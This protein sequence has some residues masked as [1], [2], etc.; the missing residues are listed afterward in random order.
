[1]QL[2]DEIISK[3]KNSH[4][5]KGFTILDDHYIVICDN[6][7]EYVEKA[8]R[9]HEQ[10]VNYCGPIECKTIDGITYALEY[11]APGVEMN[12]YYKFCDEI[13]KSAE[14]YISFFSDY[15]NTLK[16]L[17]DAPKKQYFKF[18]DDIEKMKKEGIRPDYCHYGNLF[19]DK[20]VG[21]SF[22]DVYPIRD[23]T[24]Y[25]LPVRHIFYIILNPKFNMRT[26][27]GRISVLPQ[28]LEK[29][30]NMYIYNIFQ[31]ILQGLS[32][33]GYPQE[34]VKA[35]I[36]SQGYSFDE[37][38]CLDKKQLQHMIEEKNNIKEPLL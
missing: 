25:T 1:M 15:M 9:L 7:E 19:Y 23:I 20:N 27:S 13:V 30:Y 35:F 38:S 16:I 5:D 8:K 2:T 32:Q 21:F 10:G 18:F 28:E 22:I 37:D 31:K 3:C 6:L 33:Y 12:H 4:N 24:H 11:R 34:E 36:D 26:Q 14:E 17:A 29:D